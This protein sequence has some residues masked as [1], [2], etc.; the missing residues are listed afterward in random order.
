MTAKDIMKIIG[1]IA[2]PPK[3]IE[4]SE[5]EPDIGV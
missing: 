4:L 3:T 5:S 2:K 1:P